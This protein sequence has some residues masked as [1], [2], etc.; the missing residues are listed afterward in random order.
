MLVNGLCCTFINAC[1]LADDV[2]EFACDQGWIGGGVSSPLYANQPQRAPPQSHRK[3]APA[4][5]DHSLAWSKY[6]CDKVPVYAN[7]SVTLQ[8]QPAAVSCFTLT[9][10]GV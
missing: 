5:V 2:Q 4:L 3:F 9:S 7:E 10:I 8:G 1:S 6:G